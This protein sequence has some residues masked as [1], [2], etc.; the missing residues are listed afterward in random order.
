MEK[1]SG[2][3]LDI[4][5]DPR[6]EVLKTVFPSFEDVPDLVKT[7][8][9]VTSDLRDR[10][11]DDAF[12]LILEQNGTE[13]RKF[14]T[15]DAGNTALSVEYFLKTA[16]K[17]PV[18]AQKVAA[19]NLCVACGWFGI[20]PPEELQKVAGIGDQLARAAKV[21]LIKGKAGLRKGTASL[22]S[23]AQRAGATAVGSIHSATK[24]LSRPRDLYTSGTRVLT[25]TPS[26]K[27]VGQ[28]L[29][30]QGQ[31]AVGKLLSRTGKRMESAS[32]GAL[33]KL[34]SVDLQ[35]AAV[36]KEWIRKMVSEA[37]A[38]EARLLRFADKMQRTG[39]KPGSKRGD[40]AGAAAY[41]VI[42]DTL[43]GK[44]KIGEVQ[45]RGLQR[46]KPEGG[47][48][49]GPGKG[50]GPFRGTGKGPGTGKC[51]SAARP[52]GMSP[53]EF[54]EV[55]TASIRNQLRGGKGNILVVDIDSK[56]KSREK[57]AAIDKEAIGMLPLAMGALTIPSSVSEA[58]KNLKVI[59]GMGGAIVT[60]N[61]LK[62]QR[63]RMGMI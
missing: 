7:A 4:Y 57:K 6:G 26:L 1:L 38:T 34:S 18:E 5:D 19:H 59:K 35:K 3:V 47:R 50:K 14:A 28:R 2:L 62:L 53:D 20:E 43:K 25:T 55:L 40:A 17:L 9:P 29:A 11:P 27:T 60:P 56:K 16:H 30:H 12:A 31:G 22:T 63:Q 45:G 52:L 44:S 54:Q 36:S 37:P 24:P 32:K 10:L 51:K 23:S 46:G 42:M 21:G 48:G 58:R 39:A 33:G 15:I 61:Q 41:R 49:L 8:Q 13:L